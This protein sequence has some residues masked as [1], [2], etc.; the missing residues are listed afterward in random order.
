MIM[1]NKEILKIM[2]SILI[3]KQIIRIIQKIILK[4]VL[5]IPSKIIILEIVLIKIK[6]TASHIYIKTQKK[7]V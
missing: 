2:R 5:T 1:L 4:I 7:W 6:E 3:Y